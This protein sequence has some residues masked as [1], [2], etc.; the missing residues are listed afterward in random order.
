MLSLKLTLEEQ[1]K[2]WQ[3]LELWVDPI[4]F[5]PKVL[6][7]VGGEDGS[8][9]IF[10]PAAEYKLV[11]THPTYQTAQDWLLEDEYERIQGQL[12]AEDVI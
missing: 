9:R 11:V 6:M 2:T 1:A 3:F 12:L 10:N 4:L 8:C 5:P 7:V